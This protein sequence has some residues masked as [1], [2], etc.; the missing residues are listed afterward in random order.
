[1][2]L[3]F[4]FKNLK[5]ITY[6]SDLLSHF[7]LGGFVC[8]WLWPDNQWSYTDNFILV[9]QHRH[10]TWN[11][12]KKLPLI[13]DAIPKNKIIALRGKEK[14]IVDLSPHNKPSAEKPT[15]QWAQKLISRGDR[16]AR[17]Q[18]RKITR[19]VIIEDSYGGP[20]V[21]T[22]QFS[23][24]P[25]GFVRTCFIWFNIFQRTTS[26][27]PMLN[28]CFSYV[29]KYHLV[30]SRYPTM[31]LTIAYLWVRREYG[32]KMVYLNLV[33]RNFALELSICAV[34]LMY[35]FMFL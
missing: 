29:S 27:C 15:E 26:I 22:Y 6:D 3:H 4:R 7:E 21:S 2:S 32:W 19:K 25:Q 24:S 13:G 14:L 23:F 28:K 12:K 5:L 16:I 30:D 8:R 31:C 17:S 1:M 35:S 11:Q 10:A 9:F 33:L 34:S 20:E 18:R